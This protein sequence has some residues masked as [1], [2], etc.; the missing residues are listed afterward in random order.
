MFPTST[1]PRHEQIYRCDKYSDILKLSTVPDSI[2]ITDH[3]GGFTKDF[4]NSILDS[5][6][7]K[8]QNKICVYY[9]EII[10][11]RVGINY[12]NL[13]F[14]FYFVS[15]KGRV[16]TSLENYNI[17]P[18]LNFKNFLCSFNGSVHVSRILLVSI[19]EKFGWFNPDYCS[20]H[21]QS[22]SK[23]I[24]GFVADYVTSDQETIYNKFFST[25]DD[26]NQTTHFF[27]KT[28]YDHAKNIHTLE[29]K[30]TDSFL[31]LVSETM[32]TTYYPHVTEKFLYS[33]I[34][35]GLYL[36]YAPPGWHEHVEKYYGFKR[37]TKLFDYSFDSIQN[38]IKRL[39]ELMSMISKFSILSSDEWQDLYHLE[40]DTIEYNY[41]H[42]FSKDYQK[43]LAKYV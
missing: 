22:D 43:Y 37:Y 2:Y 10:D 3:L 14:K 8:A 34:T 4:E 5:L 35:R 7:S 31:H 29:N 17:H 33:V 27:D 16:F 28:N 42:Y 15:P 9:D 32:A 25:S 40:Q 13:L 38:P 21:F 11:E 36:A 6:N 12:P 20:K 18:E 19:L 39:V 30:L 23:K 1:H 26:F 24:S 41:N